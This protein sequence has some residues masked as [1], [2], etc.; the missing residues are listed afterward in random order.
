[1]LS[2][3]NLTGGGGPLLSCLDSGQAIDALHNLIDATQK[4][5]RGDN[6]AIRPLELVRGWSCIERYY[7]DLLSANDCLSM[8]AEELLLF[9]IN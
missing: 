7:R 2:Q 5:D 4:V 8:H 6:E 9:A 3:T 1:L